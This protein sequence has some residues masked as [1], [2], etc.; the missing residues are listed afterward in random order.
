MTGSQAHGTVAAK[1]S[2]RALRIA[3]GITVLSLFSSSATPPAEAGGAHPASLIA[4]YPDIP[5]AGKTPEIDESFHGSHI[6][7]DVTQPT[8]EAFLPTKAKAT[9]AAVIVA[10]GGAFLM[11]S[12]DSEGRKV[13]AWLAEHGVAAFVLKYRLNE[14]PADPTAFGKQL[15]EVFSEAAKGRAQDITQPL[16]IA[17]GKAAV[18]L[19]RERAQAWDVDPKRI[20]FLGFSAGAVV[21]LQTALSNDQ[22]ERPDFVAPIYGP[23]DAVAV[24]AGAPPLFAALAADDPLFGGK[25][26]ALV[27]RWIE[28]K[29][30]AE[31]HVFAKGGHGFGMNATKTSSEHWIDSFYWWMQASGFLKPGKN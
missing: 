1:R 17:D 22:S 11:L 25:G 23:M 28:A 26:F 3:V 20:G 8:L 2:I 27:D 12:I 14:S 29:R 18:K 9:G 15:M 30:P 21:A 13:A 16:A 7:R 19:V 31:L 4:L 6:V 10:P 5:P 24:P